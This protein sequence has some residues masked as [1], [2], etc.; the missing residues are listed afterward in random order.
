[1]SG[2]STPPGN[3]VEVRIGAAV[4]LLVVV[5]MAVPIP[6]DTLAG[7]RPSTEPLSGSKE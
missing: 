6:F 7:G 2:G 4:M 3:N 5:V 1:L